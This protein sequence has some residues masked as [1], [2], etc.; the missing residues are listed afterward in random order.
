MTLADIRIG[1]RAYLLADSTIS[2]RVGGNRIY[3]VKLPQGITADSIVYTKISG[4]GDHHMQG[5]SGLTRP[6]IQIDSWS[7][8]MDA[9]S[10]LADLVK[11]RIDGFEGLMPWGENSPAEAIVVKGIFF[12]S[13]REGW[14]EGA[15]LYRVS[16]DYLVWYAER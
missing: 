11:E 2:T 7:Q 5:P 10:S 14:D 16:R 3:P 13:E 12:E 6:R 9:A 4:Q 1:L 8:S 15:K